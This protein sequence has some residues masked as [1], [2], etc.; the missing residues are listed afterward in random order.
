MPD[1]DTTVTF[2]EQMKDLRS[3]MF[4]IQQTQNLLLQNI[5]SQ[6]WPSLPVQKSHPLR[7]RAF[8]LGLI[9]CPFNVSLY[10]HEHRSLN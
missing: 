9:N 1:S 10:I 6:S 2:L 7:L 4:Q 8:K 5:M 3:Q